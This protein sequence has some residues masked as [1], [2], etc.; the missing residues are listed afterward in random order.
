M[1]GIVIALTFMAMMISVHCF[2]AEESYAAGNLA[3]K[4]GFYGGPYYD[5]E[6]FSHSKLS[7][8]ADKTVYV[9][10]GVDSGNF[11]RVSYAWGVPWLNLLDYANI[12]ESSVKYIHIGTSDGREEKYTTFSYSSL[13]AN[14]NAYPNMIECVNL[15]GS[16]KQQ[17]IG[18]VPESAKSGSK[19]VPTMLALG[20]SNWDRAEIIRAA[21]PTTWIEETTEEG[22]VIGK[23][24]GER[25]GFKNL[26]SSDLG[27]PNGYRLTF[28][29]STITSQNVG[30]SS[31]YINEIHIQLAGAPKITVQKKIISGKAGKAGSKYSL[32]VKISLPE[33]Y[34]YLSPEALANLKQQV[35]TGTEILSYDENVVKIKK[36][37]GGRYEAEILGEGDST[38]KFGYS[39]SEYGGG[40][41]GAEGGIAVSGADTEFDGSNPGS[42]AN[43]AKNKRADRHDTT[44][45]GI[46]E[47]AASNKEIKW[48]SAD[49]LA[50]GDNAGI[51]P[52]GDKGMA[53]AAALGIGLFALG[54]G[55]TLAFYRKEL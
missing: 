29:Q 46:G 54:F 32:N 28:G 24:P 13:S 45:M 39:R 51:T 11:M 53:G 12:D 1:C 44:Y 41:T 6:Q 7:S 55:G 14:G 50:A 52:E 47:E 5:V 21:Q 9:Y 18:S 16:L 30:T 35:L 33:N 36:I 10:T 27:C 48:I 37:K 15:E 17:A 25:T 3:V 43:N 34:S 42:A 38:V 20:Y 19:R 8:I 22:E 31:K 23:K 40:S 49:E 4:A 2:M 26:K